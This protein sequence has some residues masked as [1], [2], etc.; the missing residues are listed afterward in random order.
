MKEVGRGKG[1]AKE[2][3]KESDCGIRKGEKQ[4]TLG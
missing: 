1:N 3:E 4:E 2:E